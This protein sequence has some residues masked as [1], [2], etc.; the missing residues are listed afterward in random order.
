MQINE[1]SYCIEAWVTPGEDVLKLHNTRL[2]EYRVG[3]II[4]LD[5][6]DLE[7]YLLEDNMNFNPAEAEYLGPKLAG[8][9][10]K[11]GALSVLIT[12]HRILSSVKYRAHIAPMQKNQTT[13]AHSLA[14]GFNK[15]N[16]VSLW[17]SALI[18]G[19]MQRRRVW[20]P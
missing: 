12:T 10:R 17:R 19:L 5:R 13:G 4:E 6:A 15:I 3:D 20:I 14:K 18:Y 16:M 7:A 9:L 11:T 1:V 2:Y 8:W